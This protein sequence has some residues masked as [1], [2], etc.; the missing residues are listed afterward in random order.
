V[1]SLLAL[2]EEMVDDPPTDALPLASSPDTWRLKP[3]HNFVYSS[4]EFSRPYRTSVT[5]WI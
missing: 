2:P 4:G 5:P 1:L 3:R